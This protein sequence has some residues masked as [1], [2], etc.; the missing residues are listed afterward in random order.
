[1]ADLG[2]IMISA[3]KSN[4]VKNITNNMYKKQ[5]IFIEID[6]NTNISHRIAIGLFYHKISIACKKMSFIH[7]RFGDILFSLYVRFFKFITTLLRRL[8]MLP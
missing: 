1:V 6:K 4:G 3:K 2:Q 7:F 5:I 8:L